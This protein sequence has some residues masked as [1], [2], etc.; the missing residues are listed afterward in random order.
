MSR[1]LEDRLQQHSTPGV[2]P[3]RVS[4]PLLMPNGHRVLS[5]LRFID[6]IDMKRLQGRDNLDTFLQEAK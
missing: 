5:W 4:H 3:D 1:L 2:L 6:D